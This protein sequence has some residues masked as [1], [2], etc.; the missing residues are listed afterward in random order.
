MWKLVVSQFDRLDIQFYV[1]YERR[2]NFILFAQKCQI[3]EPFIRKVIMREEQ[4]FFFL[5]YY[6]NCKL[7][8]NKL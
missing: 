5:V 1:Q 7:L 6:S 2:V 8:C 3:C 4:S